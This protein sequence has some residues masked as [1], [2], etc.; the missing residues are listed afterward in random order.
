MNKKRF[1]IILAITFIIFNVFTHQSVA[2][3]EYK[4]LEAMPGVG[5]KGSSP[6]MSDYINGIYNFAV[7]AVVFSALLMITIGGFMYM[8]SAGNQAQAGTAKRIIID[9]LLGLVVVFTIYLI[10]HTINPDLLNISLDFSS[11]RTTT[12][13]GLQ[14]GSGQNTNSGGNGSGLP[15]GNNGT[16][17]S[18]GTGAGGP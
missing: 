15:T 8:V 18:S 4:T 13:P 14:A 9:A 10:L 1:T 16:N 17:T 11:M 5:A 6:S 2:L 12:D 3:A 7:A